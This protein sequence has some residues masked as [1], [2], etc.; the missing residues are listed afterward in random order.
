M[1]D[2]NKRYYTVSEIVRMGVMSRSTI[3]R[4]INAGK[5]EALKVGA[6]VRIP[7]EELERFISE[8]TVNGHDDALV[9]AE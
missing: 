7:A 5:L 9:V 8:H 2:L 1:S 3:W 4:Q 6:A